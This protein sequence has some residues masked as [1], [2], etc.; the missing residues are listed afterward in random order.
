MG[1]SRVTAR[2]VTEVCGDW[3]VTTATT[4]IV[5][6]LSTVCAAQSEEQKALSE[7]TRDGVDCPT[8]VELT[9]LIQPAEVVEVIVLPMVIEGPEIVFVE[10]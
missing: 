5:P 9:Q 8:V 3:F 1:G 4:V 7:R 2:P 10:D 6:P